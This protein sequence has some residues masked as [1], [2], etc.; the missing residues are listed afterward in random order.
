[1]SNPLCRCPFCFFP[2]IRS[3]RVKP[4]GAMADL[5]HPT[6]P[7][8]GEVR[9]DFLFTPGAGT[10]DYTVKPICSILI[11]FSTGHVLRSSFPI[12]DSSGPPRRRGWAVSFSSCR[13]FP[14]SPELKMEP[15]PDLF[16]PPF[17]VSPRRLMKSLRELIFFP[18]KQFLGRLFVDLLFCFRPC[19][20]HLFLPAGFLCF[21]R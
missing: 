14:P 12:F 13:L 3:C 1:M 10:G 4:H 16:P 18:F 5:A 9:P 7:P 15:P 21:S 17:T 20:E 8:T 2:R 6:F 19:G 11:F